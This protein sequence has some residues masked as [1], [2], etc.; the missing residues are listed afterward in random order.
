M[1]RFE[2]FIVSLHSYIANPLFSNFVEPP[3]PCHLQP[4]HSLFSLLSYFLGGA[5]HLM[6]YFTYDGMGL[7]MSTFGNLVP[8]GP[9]CVFYATRRQVY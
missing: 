5:A 1:G 8:E 4:P 3:L 6:C 9:W 7:H 2:I